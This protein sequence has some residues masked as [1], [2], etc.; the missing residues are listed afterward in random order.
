MDEIVS[1][2]ERELGES[3]TEV[4]RVDAG[5]LHETYELDCAGGE[6]VLQFASDADKDRRD[7]LRRGLNCYAALQNSEIPVPNLVTE[8]MTAFDGR[9]YA[10]VEK[11]PGKTAERDVSPEKVLNA[12]RYLAKI[13]NVR[14]FETAGW[15]RF[16]GGYPSVRRFREGS[17]KRRIQRTVE[18]SSGVLREGGLET[19]GTEVERLFD[20]SG[21][22]LPEEFRPVLCHD[23]YSP[24]NVLFRDGEVTGVL[25]FD[26][27]YSGHNQRDLVKAANCFWM[28][29]PCSNWDVR[30]KL[31]EGYREVNDLDS[32]FD[33][34]E[35]LYR[36]ETLVE[37]V[38]GLLEMGE[39]SEYERSFYSERL[40]DTLERAEK[41]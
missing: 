5:L 28:H 21:G 7:S 19:A 11:L 37:I 38:A 3:P 1:I 34:N 32:S 6:Y 10:L 2:A 36:V 17:L 31:Y 29:D 13:H 18:E 22:D 16:D 12:G 14:H 33:R 40:S 35:P 30:A 4:T 27:A 26:R 39:L 8:K 25:D 15:I 23:D 41:R 20:R 9:K 24:D